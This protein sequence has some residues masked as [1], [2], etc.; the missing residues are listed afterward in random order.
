[1]APKEIENDDDL[2]LFLEMRNHDKENNLLV[3]DSDDFNDKSASSDDS[4]GKPKT[5][6][7][8]SIGD[9]TADDFLN[10]EAAKTDYDWLISPPATPLFPSLD[11]ELVTKSEST[12]IKILNPKTALSNG[13]SS[14]NAGVKRRPSSSSSSRPATPTTGRAT[15][16]TFPAIIKSSS[17]PST[18]TS[19]P[20]MAARSSSSK[21]PSVIKPG[22]RSITP[23]GTQRRSSAPSSLPT[24]GISPS[25][26]SRPLKTCDV[27]N[28]KPLMNQRPS[29]AGP[30]TRNGAKTIVGNSIFVKS[31][32]QMRMDDDDE[33][34]PVLIGTKMVERVVNMRKLAPSSTSSSSSGDGSGFGRSLSKKSLDMAIRHMDIRR[35]IPGNL[36]LIKTNNGQNSSIQ[37]NSS[38][39]SSS[40][41]RGESFSDSPLATSS[42]PPSFEARN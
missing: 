24:R 15:A 25:V 40:K 31:R 39:D 6:L 9:V 13:S 21:V 16:T 34:N 22:S 28:S 30:R 19:R 5:T 1:M 2:K 23:A 26:K 3:H 29:S 20:T 32:A 41:S 4:S 8:L 17:R 35:S 11:M 38:S 12:E 18:P 7:V 36:R 10:S 37:S 27:S 33:V 42:E 14:Y